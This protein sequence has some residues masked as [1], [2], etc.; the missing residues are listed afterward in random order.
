[1]VDYKEVAR[2]V[3]EQINSNPLCTPYR[4][5]LLLRSRRDDLCKSLYTEKVDPIN[6]AESMLLINQLCLKYKGFIS[7]VTRASEAYPTAGV[8]YEKQFTQENLENFVKTF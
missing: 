7:A 3:A 8:P 5:A 1:M 6:N 2:F 4:I